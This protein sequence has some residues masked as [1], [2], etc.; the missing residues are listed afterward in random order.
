MGKPCPHYVNTSQGRRYCE[1]GD[2][3]HWGTCVGNRTQDE[4]DLLVEAAKSET[5]G[6][7]DG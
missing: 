6:Q 5:E 1:V 2:K 7:N 3:G 4:Y